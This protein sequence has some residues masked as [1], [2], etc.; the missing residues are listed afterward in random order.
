MYEHYQNKFK[1]YSNFNSNDQSFHDESQGSLIANI[2]K[3][4]AD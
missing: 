2:N 1:E 4:D 3:L